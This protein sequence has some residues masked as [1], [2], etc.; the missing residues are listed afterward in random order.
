MSLYVL[1]TDHVSLLRDGHAEVVS[2]LR[3]VA[4]E[5]RAI[6]IVTIEEQLRA[7]FTQVRRARNADQLALAYDGLF[8]VVQMARS[9]PVLPFV[10]SA[11]ARYFELRRSLRRV[12]KLDLAISAI[13]LEAN[14]ILVTRNRHDFEQ[15]PGLQIED[16]SR[17]GASD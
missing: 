15:V 8:Q 14:A 6:T 16:W 13:A 7:W 4:A 17:T 11:V 9:V 2:R 10:P 12:G 3:S 1:D 5:E